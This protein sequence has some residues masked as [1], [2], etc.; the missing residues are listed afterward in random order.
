M[1]S[2]TELVLVLFSEIDVCVSKIMKNPQITL[3]TVPI[4]NT[5]NDKS[6]NIRDI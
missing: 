6:V 3:S 2:I 1:A 5:L 4:T